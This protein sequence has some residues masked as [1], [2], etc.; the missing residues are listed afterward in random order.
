M[1]AHMSV[2]ADS[3]AALKFA[4][5]AWRRAW[6]ALIPTCLTWALALSPGR[7][8]GWTALALVS[9]L[10]ASAELYRIATPGKIGARG[11]AVGRLA[12]VWLLT[13]VFFTVLGSLLFVLFLSSAYAVASAGAGFDASE[14][15]TWAQAI[16]DRGRVVLGVVAFVGVG[17]LS[18]AMTRIALAPA[19]TVAVGRVRVLSAWPLTKG[20]GWSLLCVRVAVTVPAVGVAALALSEP[21]AGGADMAPGAWMLGALCG[22]MIGGVWLPLN[23]GLMANIYQRRANP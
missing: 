19:N 23:A 13:L 14:V 15:R 5:V 8:A 4:P 6:W 9:T 1:Q 2:V 21:R 11:A 10:F 18:W 20:I 12:V 7:A 16:D 17:L 22:L 3:R